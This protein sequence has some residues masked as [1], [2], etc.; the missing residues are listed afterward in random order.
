MGD[1]VHPR[2]FGMKPGDRLGAPQFPRARSGG[3]YPATGREASAR[4][5]SGSS[6][7]GLGAP[8][9]GRWLLLFLSLRNS[10]APGAPHSGTG[11]GF[12]TPAHWLFLAPHGV[13]W[14]AAGLTRRLDLAEATGPELRVWS[15]LTPAWQLRESQIGDLDPQG[16]TSG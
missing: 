2:Q 6:A 13:S 4:P 3:Y 12:Y 8:G 14:G 16:G 10:T 11:L 5:T 15:F 9:F 1:C 7:V